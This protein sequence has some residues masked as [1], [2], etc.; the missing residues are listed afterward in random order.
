MA[1]HSKNNCA[2]S[3]FTYHERARLSAYGTQRVRCDAD[4]LRSPTAC[5]ICLKDPP[6]APAVACLEGHL[7]CREC[8]VRSMIEQRQKM[9]ERQAEYEKQ[10][11]IL[12]LEEAADREH[13]K[14]AR[15]G[16]IERASPSVSAE[17]ETETK[18][19]AS[20]HWLKTPEASTRIAEKPETRV[21]CFGGTKAHPVSL[22][23]ICNVH[24]QAQ[25]S[26]CVCP[27]CL[28][29]LRTVAGRLLLRPCGHLLCSDC[30]Q[31]MQACFTCESEIE[32]TIE[33]VGEGT[34]YAMGGGN[35]QVHRYEPAFH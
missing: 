25:G 7:S 30:R 27:S 34:G 9:K 32:A 14:R 10:Q 3:Y 18:A 29:S 33:L 13:S 5:Y 26:L 1:R 35:V 12:E 20:D 6:Q 16:V 24:L 11:K 22:K 4:A 28:K 21:L 31:K 23:T 19:R 2:S 17:R 8:V 15:L